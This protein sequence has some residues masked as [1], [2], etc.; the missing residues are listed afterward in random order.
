MFI[1]IEKLKVKVDDFS[2]DLREIETENCACLHN[3]TRHAFGA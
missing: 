1:E 2:M 3:I